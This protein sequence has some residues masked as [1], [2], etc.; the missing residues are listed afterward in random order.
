MGLA[1]TILRPYGAYIVNEKQGMLLLLDT[2][3]PGGRCL[4]QEQYLE[5][6]RY[7]NSNKLVLAKK[8]ISPVMIEGLLETWNNSNRPGWTVYIRL[9]CKGG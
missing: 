9:F 7:A 6:P 2:N 4:A 1:S 8:I 5:M 3:F